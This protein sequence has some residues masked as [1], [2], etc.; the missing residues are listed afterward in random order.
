[1]CQKMVFSQFSKLIC[2]NF[3]S[4]SKEFFQRDFA[5]RG[6]LEIG[7]RQKSS[8]QPQNLNLQHSIGF[9]WLIDVVQKGSLDRDIETCKDLDFTNL[10]VLLLCGKYALDATQLFSIQY[11]NPNMGTGNLCYHIWKH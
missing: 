10:R 7:P 2:S 8:C 11:Q 1:V 9:N 6:H 5:A 4:R 3:L